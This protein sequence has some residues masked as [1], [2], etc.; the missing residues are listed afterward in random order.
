MAT[1]DTS[2]YTYLALYNNHWM[3]GRCV[4]GQCFAL[5]PHED[6]KREDIDQFCTIN[7]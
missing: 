1:Y 2:V 3:V 7:L 6:E 5:L 4:I